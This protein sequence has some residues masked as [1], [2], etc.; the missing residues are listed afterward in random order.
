MGKGKP[1]RVKK[2]Q[3]MERLKKYMVILLSIVL[4]VSVG[5]L[6][7]ELWDYRQGEETYGEAEK[8]VELPDFSLLPAPVSTPT[9]TPIPVSAPSESG[10]EPVPVESAKPD[11]TPTPYVDPYADALSTM[12]FAA[13]REVNEEVIGWIVIPGTTISYPLLQGEDNSYYLT[14]T[15]KGHW[16]SVGAIFMECTSDPALTDFHTI[17]YGHNM[18]NGSMFGALQNYREQ[19]HVDAH[20]S[21]Y[22]TVD[23]GTYR[24]DIFAVYQANVDSS[25]YQIGFSGEES[26][27]AFLDDC[28]SRSVVLTGVTPHTYDRILTLSTCTNIGGKTIRWV[29]QAACPGEPPPSQESSMPEENE[30]LP[31]GTDKE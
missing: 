24:Y 10:E 28:L 18:R 19:S 5:N 4:L 25:T 27:Q 13:L 9:A 3:G 26:R 22:V 12:D 29:V 7:R 8:L 20:P 11:P 2:P 21:V 6:L 31:V 1:K 17:I 14:H 15:W 23:A 16:S 30:T